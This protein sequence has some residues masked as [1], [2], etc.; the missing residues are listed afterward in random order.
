MAESSRSEEQR[1]GL[2]TGLLDELPVDRLKDELQDAL[3]AATGR[4]ADAWAAT[5]SAHS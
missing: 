3:A 1:G 5:R 4:V 2:L